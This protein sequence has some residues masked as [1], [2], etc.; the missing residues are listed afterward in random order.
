VGEHSKLKGKL[1]SW[2]SLCVECSE[3]CGLERRRLLLLLLLLLLL[4]QSFDPQER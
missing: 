2:L 4:P 3:R 1:F